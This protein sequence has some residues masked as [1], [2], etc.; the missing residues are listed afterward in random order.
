MLESNHTI[1]FDSDFEE[2]IS[3]ILLVF[4]LLI[5]HVVTT[6]YHEHLDSTRRDGSK[7]FLTGYVHYI[8]KKVNNTF[9]PNII[10]NLLIWSLLFC[11]LIR[12][13]EF[14]INSRNCNK[15]IYVDDC[16]TYKVDTNCADVAFLCTCHRRNAR[17]DTTYQR[18][19]TIWAEAWT[20]SR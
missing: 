10:V 4:F 14:S 20:N 16:G 9:L 18:W 15:D 2:K 19:V 3:I 12:L 7:A 17:A 1:W 11:H 13:F 5:C 8:E 6:L